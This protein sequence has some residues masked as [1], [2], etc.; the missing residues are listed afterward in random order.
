MP[1]VPQRGTHEHM[2]YSWWLVSTDA[3]P[4]PQHVCCLMPRAGDTARQ[5]PIS[6]EGTRLCAATP[7][8]KARI[9]PGSLMINRPT[10]S[11]QGTFSYSRIGM[12]S[13]VRPQSYFEIDLSRVTQAI[14]QPNKIRELRAR[15]FPYRGVAR[16]VTPRI[17]K[18]TIFAPCLWLNVTVLYTIQV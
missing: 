3:G 1:T 7:S 4:A 11:L 15:A 8:L 12:V 6:L 16:R 14:I 18:A 17:E 9:A 5:E 13:R 2:A 10:A